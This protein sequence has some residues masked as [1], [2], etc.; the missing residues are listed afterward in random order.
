MIPPE[1]GAPRI[2]TGRGPTIAPR[3]LQVTEHE[4][5]ESGGDSETVTYQSRD[6][7]YD[8]RQPWRIS[9]ATGAVVVDPE[10]MVV[11]EVEASWEVT[12]GAATYAE[13]LLADSNDQTITYEYRP[14]EPDIAEP[15]WVEVARDARGGE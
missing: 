10:T 5:V 7:W 4:R 9:D 1:P 15:A 12:P 8:D 3:T 6:G 2:E 11:H 13:A 14:E